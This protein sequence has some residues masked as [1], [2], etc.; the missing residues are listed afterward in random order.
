MLEIMSNEELAQAKI[1]VIGVGGR[2][3][4]DGKQVGNAGLILFIELHAHPYWSERECSVTCG[5][6]KWNQC[7]RHYF[8]MRR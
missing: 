4:V 6:Q 3:A 5:S 2:G 1:L 8:E 7:D